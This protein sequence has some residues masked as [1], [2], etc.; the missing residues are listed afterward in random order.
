MVHTVWLKALKAIWGMQLLPVVS[1]CSSSWL[2]RIISSRKHILSIFF[3]ACRRSLFSVND[4]STS[5]TVVVVV[6]VIAVVVVVVAVI[7]V[8]AVIVRSGLSPDHPRLAASAANWA[9]KW[10]EARMISTEGAPILFSLWH[11]KK[12]RRWRSSVCAAT[13]RRPT[14][15]S[16]SCGCRCCCCQCWAIQLPTGKPPTRRILCHLR[17]TSLSSPLEF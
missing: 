12:F 3:N 1:H 7:A 2:Q 13:W 8:I 11:Q 14:C 15:S 17:P 9:A 6:V 5:R 10:A 16:R 4:W